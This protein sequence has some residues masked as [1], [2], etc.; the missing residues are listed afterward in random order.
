M[1]SQDQMIF[2]YVFMNSV[3]F[4]FCLRFVLSIFRFEYDYC[5]VSKYGFIITYIIQ[6][7]INI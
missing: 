3:Y 2:I 7:Y 6:I 1:L 4:L 5:L